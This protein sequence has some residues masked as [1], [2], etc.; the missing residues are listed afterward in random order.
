ME[1]SSTLTP[2]TM[3]PLHRSHTLRIL[4][5]AVALVSLLLSA[6]PAWANSQSDR[7]KVQKQKAAVAA[8]INALRATD[9]QVTAALST[10][11]ENVRVQ[12]AALRDA[13]RKAAAAEAA[14]AEATAEVTAKQAEIGELDAAVKELAITAYI[15]PPAS[16]GLVDA[17][18]SETIGEAEL[19]QSLL[20][21]K[22]ASQLDALDQ[23]ERAREDLEIARAAAERASAEAE[24]NRNSV[25]SRLADVTE[26]RNQQAG[27]AAQ[28][29]ARLEHKLGE[30]ANLAELDRKLAAEIAAEQARLSAQL[31]SRRGSGGGGPIAITG[32]G[33]I[34]SVRGI[35]VHK[36][37]A[38][39]T[40][41]LLE[42]AEA[43]GIS[44]SGGGYR[45]SQAQIETRKRNCGTSYYDVYQ[46][47]PNQC[48]PPTARPGQS[49]HE[50]GLA[51]D[52]TY[53]GRVINSRSSPA[54][55]WLKA[56][57]ASYGFYNLPSEAWHWSVNGD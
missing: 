40:A 7:S 14:L 27:L 28:I 16:S 30:A 12:A 56:H 8:E 52:F 34:V 29:D 53:Q 31:G 25:D 49:M 5:S 38:S 33:D 48:S 55:Q 32:S 6:T 15:H 13:E 26:A 50:R 37:I 41:N 17:L 21:A 20:E 51:I 4:A 43:D 42:A 19:K 39:N 54:F 57:A 18:E 36:S 2:R 22:S 10:L 3:Q 11:N 1:R 23:L 46:K 47:P 35:R 9:A 45:D 44:L 24:A